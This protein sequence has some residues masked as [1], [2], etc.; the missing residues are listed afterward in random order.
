[1]DENEFPALTQKCVPQES[2]QNSLF[3]GDIEIPLIEDLK[4][5]FRKKIISLWKENTL[6]QEECD[7]ILSKIDN[8]P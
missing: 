2:I 7:S 8:E 1:M 5:S 6:T 3:V 4:S